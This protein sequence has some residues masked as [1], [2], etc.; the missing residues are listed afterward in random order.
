MVE[1]LSHVWDP[2]VPHWQYSL[3]IRRERRVNSRSRYIIAMVMF[4]LCFHA[5]PGG[6]F[7]KTSKSQDGVRLL[8]VCV[9]VCARVILSN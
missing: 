8:L 6:S 4:V 3:R 9:C 5:Q 1:K 7:I 2:D